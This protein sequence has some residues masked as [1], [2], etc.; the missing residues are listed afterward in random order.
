MGPSEA[1]SKRIGILLCLHAVS[2]CRK[3]EQQDVP[4]AAELPDAVLAQILQHIP[5]WQRLST[6]TLV[7]K[8]WQAAVTS[9]TG[10]VDY[11]LCC[12]R[13]RQHLQAW[14][15]QCGEQVVSMELTATIG[16]RREGLSFELPC[17][18][19]SQLESLSASALVLQLHSGRTHVSTRSS[20]GGTRSVS[21][22]TAAL[23]RAGPTSGTGF[24]PKLQQLKLEA[25][26][27][28]AQH[29]V[30]LSKLTA[31]DSLHVDS[32]RLWTHTN[33][34]VRATNR[35]LQTVLQQLTKLS[36]L[37]LIDLAVGAD[38][39]TASALAPISSMQH[40]QYLVLDDE[41]CS[42]FAALLPV[43]PTSLA[44]LQLNGVDITLPLE[45][46]QAFSRLGSLQELMLTG[47]FMDPQVRS[48][49]FLY[50]CHSCHTV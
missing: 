17:G 28:L 16:M 44:V 13:E 30:Q 20:R 8:A 27:M 22:P 49:L 26:S 6:C 7:C 32:L 39:A 38:D 1:H 46:M 15:Q 35:A 25:C 50:S 4:A 47:V 40:L 45:H 37:T 48:V 21:Y 2:A 43:L 9:T 33:K 29:F 18:K 36:S 11:K 41:T 12:V 23:G 24:L 5:L 14:L 10:D 3:V 31:L 19:L 34:P 42:N